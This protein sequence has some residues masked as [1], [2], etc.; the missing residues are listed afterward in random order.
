MNTITTDGSRWNQ[1]DFFDSD[2]MNQKSV[3]K[4]L[5]KNLTLV[6][7]MFLPVVG[8]VV[9]AT[10]VLQQVAGLGAIGG[11]MMASLLDIETPGLNNL[12]GMV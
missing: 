8:P 5:A 10:S 9:A 2:D 12:E 11:K 3:G 1:Y 7:S 6:G 4:T